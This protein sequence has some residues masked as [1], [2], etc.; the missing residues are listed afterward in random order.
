MADKGGRSESP[1][2]TSAARH[3][4]PSVPSPHQE[5]M[6]TQ[7]CRQIG[8]ILGVLEIHR[9]QITCNGRWPQGESDI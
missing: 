2:S 9:V 7:L 4:S 8:D 1:V 6:E 5:W 3:L